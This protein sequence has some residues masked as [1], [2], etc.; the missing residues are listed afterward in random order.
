MKYI[1]ITAFYLVLFTACQQEKIEIPNNGRKIVINGLITTDNLINVAIRQSFNLKTFGRGE[2]YFNDSAS[3]YIFQNDTC[4]D[5]LYYDDEGSHHAYFYSDEQVI[6]NYYSKSVYPLPGKEY[7]ILVKKNGLPDATS[8][9]IIPDVVKI[10]KIDTSR[11]K[12]APDTTQTDYLITDDILI[13]NIEFTDPANENNYYYFDVI[14]HFYSYCVYYNYDVNPN[15]LDTQIFHTGRSAYINCTDPI[16]DEKLET[17]GLIFSDKLINGRKYKLS[18][19]LNAGPMSRGS[20]TP[21]KS[22][23]YFRLHSISKEYCTYIK[24]LKLY[25][26]NYDNPLSEPVFVNSNV[27]GGYGFFSGSA[28]SSDSVVFKY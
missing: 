17:G 15:V 8:K 7:S 19:S 11:I 23:F 27:I 14:N 25:S 16:V 22:V 20:F 4:I 13:C 1:V 28:V 2:H 26:K 24:A 18:I 12:V 9:T 3:V 10:E 5:S 21:L 6:S